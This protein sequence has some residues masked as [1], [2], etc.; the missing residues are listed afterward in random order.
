MQ[1]ALFYMLFATHDPLKILNPLPYL[2]ALRLYSGN[3]IF[4]IIFL[5]TTD[6]T[7]TIGI[8]HAHDSA[9]S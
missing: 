1:G 9:R 3:I 5:S 8:E 2:L 6:H 4:V 7:N